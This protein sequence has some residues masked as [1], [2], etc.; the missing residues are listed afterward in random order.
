MATTYVLFEQDTT[1]YTGDSGRLQA[2]K[3]PIIGIGRWKMETDSG[4]A[5]LE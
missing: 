2:S 3:N 5:Q 4:Q 1:F